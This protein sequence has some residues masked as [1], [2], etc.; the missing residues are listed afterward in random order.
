MGSETP[1]NPPGDFGRRI[2]VSPDARITGWAILVARAP[3]TPRAALEFEVM[4]LCHQLAVW[5]R[6]APPSTAF[7]CGRLFWV[8]LYRARPRCLEPDGPG[9]PASMVMQ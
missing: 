9:E 4:A 5:R 2:V 8:W 7:R 3:L 1:T 6:R